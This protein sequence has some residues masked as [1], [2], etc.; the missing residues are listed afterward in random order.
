MDTVIYIAL[1]GAAIGI[2]ASGIGFRMMMKNTINQMK[3]DK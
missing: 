3:K 2:I 1:A